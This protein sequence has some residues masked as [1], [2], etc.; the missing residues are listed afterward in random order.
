MVGTSG[1][2]VFRPEVRRTIGWLGGKAVEVLGLGGGVKI[3]IWCSCWTT[4]AAW[5]SW[6]AYLGVA[7]DDILFWG[8]WARRCWTSWGLR[9]EGI[10]TNHSAL[11][12]Y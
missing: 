8:A 3:W 5:A 10:F 1:S 2:H 6:V 4:D 7:M 9:E 12:V 11:F